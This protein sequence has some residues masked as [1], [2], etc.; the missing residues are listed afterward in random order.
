M[1]DDVETVPVVV[2]VGEY[3]FDL[4]VGTDIAGQ[5]DVGLGLGRELS[6]PFLELVV[7]VG[8]GDLGAFPVHGLGDAPGDGT[9]AGDADDQCPFSCQESHVSS[10]LSVCD[11]PHLRRGILPV[12]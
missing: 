2:Q 9:I 8:V 6:H 7:L 11:A 1:D 4:L 5:E 10:P 12:Q 3:G